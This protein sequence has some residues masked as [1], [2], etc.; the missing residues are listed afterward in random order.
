MIDHVGIAVTDLSL[1][2]QTYITTLGFKLLSR[3]VLPER[4]IEV[5]ML[6]GGIELVAPLREG[7]EVSRF[8]DK[9]GEGLHHLAVRVPDVAQALTDMARRGATLIDQK[10]RQGAHQTLVG[11]L[12]PRGCHGVLIELVQPQETR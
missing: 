12:H 1:A 3:E 6:E 8:L 9:R 7:S 5:A 11:F 10:P 2:L 4:G